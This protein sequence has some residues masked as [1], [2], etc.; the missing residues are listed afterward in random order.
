MTIREL[1]FASLCKG[2]RYVTVKFV[3]W[4]PP[5]TV[6]YLLSRAAFYFI[7]CYFVTSARSVSWLCPA[8]HY[9]LTELA[10]VS[11]KLLI[12]FLP[13]A[14]TPAFLG[15]LL[16]GYLVLALERP[17]WQEWGVVPLPVSLSSASRR[18]GVL[19]VIQIIKNQNQYPPKFAA[20]TNAEQLC[21]RVCFLLISS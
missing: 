8:S 7:S 17:W 2:Q 11:G 21:C 13:V 9:I 15:L 18:R 16:P 4:W 19:F 6:C 3:I 10:N 14:L 5:G 20:A 1:T 12:A